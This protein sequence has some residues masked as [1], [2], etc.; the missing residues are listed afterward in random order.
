MAAQD[1]NT[2]KYLKRALRLA[3]KGEGL[4]SPNPLVGAV[5]VKD[6]R[7]IG[8]GYHQHFG[9]DHAEVDALKNVT[10]SPEGSTLYINLEPCCHFGK[11]PPCTEA[12]IKAGIKKVVAAMPD[13]NP[14]VSG[15]GFSRL[16]KTG[17]EVETG[18]LFEESLRINESYFTW[19]TQRRPFITLK[20]A[21]SLDGKITSYTGKSKWITGEEARRFAHRLRF[22]YDAVLVGIK[23]VLADD[24]SL[25]YLVP[26]LSL[27]LVSHKRYFKIVLDNQARI[28]LSAKLW[29]GKGRVVVATTEKAPSSNLRR[30]EE[31]GARILVAGAERVAIKKLLNLLYKMEVGSVLVEGGAETFGSFV[32]EKM[33][34]LLYVF[35]SP[36]VL[37]NRNAKSSIAGKGFPTP[38]EALRF[39]FKAMRHFGPD[40]L[41]IYK[42]YL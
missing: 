31:K 24:P 27:S 11:T 9:G 16:K 13:P 29:K 40:S 3:K 12:L 37:G 23:T 35:Q 32:D 26:K 34:D 20:I 33:V 42:P 1:N 7:I 17:I 22:E 10:E 18:L 41:S 8:E 28:P 25:D 19:I 4:V 2:E 39:K 38:E 30:L 21:Q 5:L 6:N 36:I 14:L 15:K